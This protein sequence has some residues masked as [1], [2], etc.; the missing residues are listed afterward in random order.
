MRKSPDVLRTCRLLVAGLATV[1]ASLV[2]RAQMPNIDTSSAYSHPETRVPAPSRWQAHTS[3]RIH[4]RF[5]GLESDVAFFGSGENEQI[6][7][8]TTILVGPQITL[9]APHG[10]RFFAHSL[11]GVA[12][13]TNT[14]ADI[15]TDDEAYAYALGGGLDL[16]VTPRLAVRVQVDRL[17]VPSLR[18]VNANRAHFSIGGVFRY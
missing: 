16:P 6:K 13:A 10:C 2:A 18:S 1:F 11:F 3:I 15:P 9:H 5:A 7:R 17:E 14:L 12:H 4:K 8:S